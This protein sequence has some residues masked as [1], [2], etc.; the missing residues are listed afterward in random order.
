MGLGF[1]FLGFIVL[2]F[3][4]KGIGFSVSGFRVFVSRFRV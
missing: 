1:W 4:V 3:R 2:S